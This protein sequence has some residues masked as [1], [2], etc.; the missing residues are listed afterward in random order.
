MRWVDDQDDVLLPVPQRRLRA[1][2]DGSRRGPP[3]RP[4][5]TFDIKVEGGQLLVNL[6]V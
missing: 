3:P 1:R 4:L 5:D 2:T 6:E